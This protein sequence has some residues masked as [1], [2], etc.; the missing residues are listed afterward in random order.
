MCACFS[1]ACNEQN[2]H[3]KRFALTCSSF[4]KQSVKLKLQW[5]FSMLVHAGE[6]NTFLQDI[7]SG[8][9]R[10]NTRTFKP[11]PLFLFEN[12]FKTFRGFTNYKKDT[13]TWKETSTEKPTLTRTKHGMHANHWTDQGRTATAQQE[14]HGQVWKSP[15]VHSKTC[16]SGAVAW[17]RG[18]H[19]YS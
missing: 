2:R 16:V 9:G 13:H 19:K 6:K 3:F 8:F 10:Q 15:I 12:F 14:Q 17:V 18:T 1:D 5:N 4:F 7:I 11:L